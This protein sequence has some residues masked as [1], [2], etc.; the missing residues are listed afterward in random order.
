MGVS[1]EK[2]CK[3]ESVIKRY[4]CKYVVL[5]ASVYCFMGVRI[6]FYGRAYIVL[7][8]SVY[9]FMG[10]RILFYGRA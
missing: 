9:C 6:L 10:E 2:R 8:A 5:W 7:W 1:N 4:Y 3:I